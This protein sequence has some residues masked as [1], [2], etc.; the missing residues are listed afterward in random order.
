MVKV[1][2]VVGVVIKVVDGTDVRV[3]VEA[4]DGSGVRVVAVC[5]VVTVFVVV[6]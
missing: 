5:F 2:A 6:F 3:V 4:V 1:A